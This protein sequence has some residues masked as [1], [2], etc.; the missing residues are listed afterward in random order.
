MSTFC[1][2]VLRHFFICTFLFLMSIVN[3]VYLKFINNVCI[4][5]LL[6][7]FLLSGDIEINPGSNYK[8]NKC[9]PLS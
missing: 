9:S 5:L 6:F 8:S 2:L 7:I 3:F 4:L 1:F